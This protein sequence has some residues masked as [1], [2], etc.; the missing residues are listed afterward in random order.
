MKDRF[1][2]KDE[3][4]ERK[5]FEGGAMIEPKDGKGRFELISPFALMRLARVYQKGGVKYSPRNWETGEPFS[6]FIDSAIRH[7]EQY[8]MG[9]KDED[10]LGQASWNLFCV[11]HFEETGR[12][13]LDDLPHYIDKM[14][15]LNSGPAEDKPVVLGEIHCMLCDSVITVEAGRGYVCPN[16]GVIPWNTCYIPNNTGGASGRNIEAG[17]KVES[18]GGEIPPPKVTPKWYCLVCGSEVTAYKPTGEPWEPKPY[19]GILPYVCPIHGIVDH[20]EDSSSKCGT[21]RGK[22][23]H[24][25]QCRTCH[26]PVH[27][28][29]TGGMPIWHC[30]TCGNLN[31]SGLENKK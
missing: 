19:L 5:T 29:Y 20:V 17:R 22:I 11:M 9:M 26:T 25:Y 16:C 28:E 4:K 31:P 15:S 14:K 13:D 24:Q 27:V 3:T 21:F 12:W 6:R 30:P 2:L 8:L 10:H 23:S 1:T 18:S 7:I